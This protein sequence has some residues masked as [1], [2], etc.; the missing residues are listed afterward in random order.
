VG[1]RVV[2]G[3]PK[4]DGPVVVNADILEALEALTSWAPLHQPACL[5]PIRTILTGR[6]ELIQ[7]ACFDT[8]FHKDIPPANGRFPL[9]ARFAENG[10]R[11]YGFHG[12]S[13]EAIIRRLD[14]ARAR[15]VVAHLGGGC[16]VCAIW[17]GKS[18]NTTMSLTPLDGLMMSTRCGAIDPGLVL[19]LQRSEGMSLSEVEDLLYHGSGLLGVSGISAD[20]RALTASQDHL[21]KA[22]V[23]QFCARAAEAIAAM[24][25]SI[26]G[27]E[28]L[29][30]TGGIGEGSA[31]VRRNI[32]SRLAWLGVALDSLAN[33]AHRSAISQAHCRPT[34]RVIPTDEEAVIAAQTCSLTMG[35]HQASGS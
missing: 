31:E 29:V 21:A 6:P 14:A 26:G 30:F 9:P 10:I 24:S 17:N 12:L 33:E 27:L 13:F 5:S 4:F 22:A 7:V 1:H 18:V 20:M 28:I 16:S 19:F 15:V 35:L 3:G 32:C 11:R 2:H 34:V 25:I 23:D 8:A